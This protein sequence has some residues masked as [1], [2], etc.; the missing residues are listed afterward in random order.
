MGVPGVDPARALR[1]ADSVGAR[2]MLLLGI[3]MVERVLDVRPFPVLADLAAADPHVSSLADVLM[4][5][6]LSPGGADHR[7]GRARVASRLLLADRRVDGV[8]GAWRAVVT[9]K[10]TDWSAVSLPDELYGG[11][12]LVRMLRVARYVLRLGGGR[13]SDVFDEH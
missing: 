8:L 2:R 1:L 5:A 7:S 12:Y 13:A 6:L 10:P 3:S 9:P 4:P 11:Y